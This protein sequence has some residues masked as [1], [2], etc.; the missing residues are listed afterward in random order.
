MAV[1][2]GPSHQGLTNIFQKNIDDIRSLV[3]CRICIRPMYEPYTTQCGHTFCYSCLRQWFDRGHIKK[4][5][6]DCRAHVQNQP[7][8]A[9]LVRLLN[10][11]TFHSPMLIHVQV[12]EITQTFINTGVLLPAG[13][14]TEDHRKSQ[15][16]EAD[17]VEKDKAAQVSGR[18]LFNGRFNG[19][20]RYIAPIRDALDGVDRCPRV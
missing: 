10:R 19:P 9:F 6:P 4:T 3:A 5:C 11:S 7:A 8:P 15:R 1:N 17:L 13:E 18:G 2:S 12:R 14:T 16:E 20:A